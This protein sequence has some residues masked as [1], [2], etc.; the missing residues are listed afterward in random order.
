MKSEA[1]EIIVAF[2][3]SGGPIFCTLHLKG[4]T[5]IAKLADN[6]QAPVETLTGEYSNR[7]DNIIS[8]T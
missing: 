4:A 1:L 2:C 7:I 3:T 6:S 8:P 5:T